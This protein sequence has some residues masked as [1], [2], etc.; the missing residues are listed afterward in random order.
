MSLSALDLILQDYATVTE[1]NTARLSP[2]RNSLVVITGGTGFMGTWLTGLIAF[3]NDHY[4][5]NTNV[6][7]YAR[8]IDYFKATRPHLSHRSD[9]KLTSCDVRYLV[10]VPQ[11]TNWLVHAAG[12][13]DNRFHATSP[14]ETMSIIANGT[15]SVLRAVER[16]SNLKMLLNVSSGLV[17]GSQPH[18]V[19]YLN[20][21]FL[22]APKCSTVSSAYAEAKRFAETLCHSSRSQAR[23]P[24]VTARPFAFIGPYQSLE[25]PWAINNFIKDAISGNAIRILGDGET[26]RSY[27]Y[28]SDMALWLLTILTQGKSGEAYNVGSPEAISLGNLA[29]IVASQMDSSLEVKLKTATAPSNSLQN[30]RFVPDVSL[31]KNELQLT[32]SVD[33]ETAVQRTIEWNKR[34]SREP[35]LNTAIA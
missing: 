20:E 13:P 24:I 17:Y 10:E 11:E 30:S 5:F 19:A 18:D 16:C 23:T 28:A 1:N 31:A 22:G 2:L 4:G 3:L 34:Y 21:N 26:I 7:L 33:L 12:T 25:R 14:I 8:N 35:V 29:Q 9:I 27:M 32:Q 15:Y 6:I